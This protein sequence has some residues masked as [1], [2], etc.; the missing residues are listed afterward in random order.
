MIENLWRMSIYGTVLILV[1]LVIRLFLGKYPKVYSCSLWLM[2]LIRLLCPVFIPGSYSFQPDLQEIS[3]IYEHMDDGPQILA[4]ENGTKPDVPEQKNHVN[5]AE[6]LSEFR[7]TETFAWEQLIK[8]AY[9]TGL[10]ITAAVFLIQFFRLKKWISAAVPDGKNIWLCDESVMEEASMPE[11]K[12]YADI[13][14]KLAVRQS[15]FAPLAFNESNTEKR[16]KNVLKGRKERTVFLVLFFSLF[17]VFCG[18]AFMT[19][20]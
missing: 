19:V 20:P 16:I 1:V 14:L 2:V 10:C 9:L 8:L 3:V 7:A 15:G 18:A 4:E 12:I 11:R 5:P 17:A 6:D 13:L